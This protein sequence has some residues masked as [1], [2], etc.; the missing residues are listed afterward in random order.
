MEAKYLLENKGAVTWS[1]Q[2]WGCWNLTWSTCGT[3]QANGCIWSGSQKNVI[4]KR[5]TF[6][7]FF[8]TFHLPP[9]TSTPF[10]AACQHIL[11]CARQAKLWHILIDL[12]PRRGLPVVGVKTS[13]YFFRIIFK[14]S[15][16]P[17]HQRCSLV[18]YGS[19]TRRRPSVWTATPRLTGTPP[20]HL[21]IVGR[22]LSQ[23]PPPSWKQQ[24]KAATGA[25]F[26]HE[27]LYC[28]L[29][30]TGMHDGL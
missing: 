27:G 24:S 20:R 14:K 17:M 25:Q 7:F 26:P 15:S 16:C 1:P 12:I 29:Q 23:E 18:P 28:I 4:I 2:G 21:A 3:V 9:T 13:K 11:G 5:L 10:M 19:K 8:P 30:R 6:L 22:G